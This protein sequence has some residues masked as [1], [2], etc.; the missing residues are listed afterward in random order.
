MSSTE[1]AGVSL[2]P[3]TVAPELRRLIGDLYVFGQ[4]LA[5]DP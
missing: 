1:R 5:G 2:L 4:Q 3:E